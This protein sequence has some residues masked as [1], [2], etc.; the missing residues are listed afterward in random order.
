MRRGLQFE[1]AI[2]SALNLFY[3]EYRIP[4]IAY[5]RWAPPLVRLEFDVLSDSLRMPYYCAIECKTFSLG[6]TKSLYF[7][8]HFSSPKG[9]HQ[10]GREE[11]WLKKTGRR[12]YLAVEVRAGSGNARRAYLVPFREVLDR[13]RDN[14]AGLPLKWLETQP[15]LTREGKRYVLDGSE[16]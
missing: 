6:A 2:T 15:Q 8:Q 14:Y 7:K 5:R 3:Q 1:Q 4:A 12:G 9:E 16:F 10:L 11:A 13:W